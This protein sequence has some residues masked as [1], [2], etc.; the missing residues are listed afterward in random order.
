MSLQYLKKEVT[1]EVDFL[2]AGKHQSF[3]KVYFNSLGIKVF[4]KVDIIIIIGHDQVF[5]N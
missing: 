4:H 2:H 5:S 1:Y 3:L